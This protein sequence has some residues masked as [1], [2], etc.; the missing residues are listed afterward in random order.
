[1]YAFTTLEDVMS[2]TNIK[3]PIAFD[4]ETDG[5]Y[6]QIEVAQFY[7]P[8][9]PEVKLVR[10]PEPYTLANFIKEV[11]PI[12]H[13]L[14]YDFSVLQTQTGANWLPGEFIDTFYLSRL[15]YYTKEK[16]TLDDVLSYVLG[17][18]PYEQAGLSKKDLQKSSWSGLLSP[19]QEMYAALDVFHM[20]EVLDKLSEMQDDF[21]YKLDI[22][23]TRYCLEF[24]QNGMPVLAEELQN[25]YRSNLA[26][27]DE[28]ALPINVNSWQQVRPYIGE[29]ESDGLALA[30]FALQGNE[31]AAQVNEVRKLIK[32]NSFLTKFDVASGRI[33]GR[34]KPS[35]RSGRCTCGDQNLQQIPRK[36]KDVFGV[37]P[38]S[39]RS[40]IYSDYSQLELRG[41]CAITG[42]LRMEELF[43]SGEDLHQY[44]ADMIKASR[45]VAKTANFNLLYGGS[46]GMLGS[47]LIKDAG[48]LVP[49]AE[50]AM[51]KKKW[52]NLWTGIYAWQQRGIAAWRKK[53]PWQTPLGRRYVGKLMTDHLNIQV[54]GF[55]AEVAKLATH[56]MMPAL[57]G[58]PGD[59]K[60]CN[61]VH[62]SWVLECDNDRSV[63]EQVARVM[64]EAMQEAWFECC[65]STKIKDLPMP[66]DVYAGF[67]WGKIEDEHIY[68]FT[69]E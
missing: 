34:F 18:D 15:Y 62:D 54:Q 68:K 22:L 27:I 36:T 3:Q 20:F 43:R 56:Y 11:T 9:W 33:Y 8:H 46:H 17:Y 16:F 48:L 24:Q 35:A 5:F 52:Q 61:F 31:R 40:L 57:R 51:I 66:V 29:S 13:N 28:L 53:Q 58:L 26:R 67:N 14:H 32:Q 59:I 47:I 19:A 45:Q 39:G 69:K 38:D 25:R 21:S 30:T 7:Q 60:V 1:M 12:G 41:G 44:T 37:E 64:S 42:E 65:R 10:K 23:F 55:G 50:L 49:E 63:H 2:S 4:T 6:G